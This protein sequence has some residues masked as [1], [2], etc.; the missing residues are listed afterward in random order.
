MVWCVLEKGETAP[1]AVKHCAQRRSANRTRARLSDQGY[2]H[3]RCWAQ[4]ALI[5]VSSH[6]TQGCLSWGLGA[7]A[8]ATPAPR[9]LTVKTRRVDESKYIFDQEL[10][11]SN[12]EPADML[13]SKQ[14]RCVYCSVP[15]GDPPLRKSLTT[16]FPARPL[17]EKLRDEAND[18][19]RYEKW[20]EN[21]ASGKM[22]RVKKPPKIRWR[23]TRFIVDAFKEVDFNGRRPRQTG[24]ITELDRQLTRFAKLDTLDVSN[25]KITVLEN[26]PPSLRVLQAY[27]NRI[28]AVKLPES[29]GQLLHLGLGY[30]R[31]SSIASIADAA[32]DTLLSLDLAFN[33]IDDI[34]PAAAALRRMTRLRQLNLNGNPICLLQNYV[35][36]ITKAVPTL[37]V[38]DGV[39]LGESGKQGEKSEETREDEAK[40]GESK[41]KGDGDAKEVAGTS[42][43]SETTLTDGSRLDAM[44]QNRKAMMRLTMYVGAVN[45]LAQPEIPE[46]EEPAEGE[47]RTELTV[48][49]Y[50]QWRLGDGKT[51]TTEPF[52]WSEEEGPIK[53]DFFGDRRF[54]PSL[55]WCRF[56]SMLGVDIVLIQRTT[57]T[58]TTP[59]PAPAEG[60]EPAEDEQEKQPTVEKSVKSKVAGVGHI[61]T[62]IVLEPSA[63][64]KSAECGDKGMIRLERVVPLAPVTQSEMD[65]KVWDPSGEWRTPAMLWNREQVLEWIRATLS[66]DAAARDRVITA[67]KAMA[68]DGKGLVE[69]FGSSAKGAGLGYDGATVRQ[70]LQEDLK[71]GVMS[72]ADEIALRRGVGQLLSAPTVA[73]RSESSAKEE[74]AKAIPTVSI[75]FCL[76]PKNDELTRPTIPKEEDA[77]EAG[78][79]KGK[80]KK[81]GKK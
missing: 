18:V 31:I 68:L 70:P 6:E 32:A 41:A 19:R 42:D 63:R 10:L 5:K 12:Y 11:E 52:S 45:G 37:R 51:C 33:Q 14:S 27:G 30:N 54:R 20:F 39:K 48:D 55:A 7:H 40:N 8:Y 75:V 72:T 43:G 35:S 25:N 23:N 53:V 1:A 15:L 76:N 9:S 34:V 50:L 2:G 46:Q 81:K 80:K 57:T 17:F 58:V 69:K 73:P 78:N 79:A 44:I 47:P 36:V 61:D 62:S 74:D 49:Y 77:D 4:A 66:K 38:L 56:F 60:E 13:F 29:R 16:R 65:A 67:V 28:R 71:F 64:I 3:R 24:A 21:K 26:L 59:P 22:M